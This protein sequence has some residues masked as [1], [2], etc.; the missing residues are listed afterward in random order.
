MKM[1]KQKIK[2]YN[3]EH[4]KYLNKIND[5]MCKVSAII[6]ACDKDSEN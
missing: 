1:F 3:D 4:K 2:V 5:S 6:I